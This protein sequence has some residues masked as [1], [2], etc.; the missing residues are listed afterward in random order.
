MQELGC[1]TDSEYENAVRAFDLP[2]ISHSGGS[3]GPV[4]Y[5]L[6]SE[7]SEPIITDLVGIRP[8]TFVLVV[9]IVVLII[10]LWLKYSR[11]NRHPIRGDH[12][13]S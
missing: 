3:R 10:G 11:R 13:L 6:S 5:V 4:T 7:P 2:N 12:F 9:G 8:L 1:L